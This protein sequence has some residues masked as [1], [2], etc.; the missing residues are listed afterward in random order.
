MIFV[1]DVLLVLRKNGYKK[2]PPQAANLG[3]RLINIKVLRG[4]T[5]IP[6]E[7][8]HRALKKAFNGATRFCLIGKIFSAKPLAGELRK[9]FKSAEKL[10]AQRLFLSFRKNKTYSPGQ[11]VI[12]INN[13]RDNNIIK[14]NFQPFFRL[15]NK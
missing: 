2:A 6:D 10:S 9:N 8:I 1:Y 3:R 13:K 11:R 4:T 15:K 12:Y 7:K 5:R 14:S